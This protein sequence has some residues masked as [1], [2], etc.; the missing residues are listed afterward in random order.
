M[1]QYECSTNNHQADLDA[2][3]YFTR[4]LLS[5]GCSFLEPVL[6]CSILCARKAGALY[7]RDRWRG[8]ARTNVPRTSGVLEVGLMDPQSVPRDCV[9]GRGAWR[10]HVD[11]QAVV[12]INTEGS[13]RRAREGFPAR[14]NSPY[15]NQTA[16]RKD[17]NQDGLTI[18]LVAESGEERISLL[19]RREGRRW[20][21]IW[22]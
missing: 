14:W 4:T 10:L 15:S 21:E 13:A 1:S 2:H 5:N 7:L 20:W 3:C 6:I 12:T 22:L 11:W 19:L 16:L 8:G 17:K 18:I 9:G